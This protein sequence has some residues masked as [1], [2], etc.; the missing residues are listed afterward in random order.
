MVPFALLP[1][2]SAF[3]IHV[4]QLS[5]HTKDMVESPRVSLLV[6]VPDTGGVEVDI[7]R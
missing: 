7:V 3:V 5:S 6:V 1:N 2:A 4:S